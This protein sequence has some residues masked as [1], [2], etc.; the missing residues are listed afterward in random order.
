MGKSNRKCFLCG[1]SYYYCSSCFNDYNKPSWMIM[2]DKESC[3]NIFNAL[4]L[5]YQGTLSDEE[6]LD[7]IEN[8]DIEELESFVEVPKQQIKDLLKKRKHKNDEEQVN[9][10]PKKSTK[11][12]IK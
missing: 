7:V 1:K 10:A 8:G 12:K 2:F 5:N 4:Q 3:F 9:L 11:T 6:T